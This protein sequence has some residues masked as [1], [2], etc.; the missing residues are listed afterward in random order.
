MILNDPFL[1]IAIMFMIPAIIVTVMAIIL[2][3]KDHTFLS[4][5]GHMIGLLLATGAVMSASFGWYLSHEKQINPW[6]ERLI[7]WI[8]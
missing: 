4:A 8:G 6:I 2:H 1:A 3:S 7:Q 5:V